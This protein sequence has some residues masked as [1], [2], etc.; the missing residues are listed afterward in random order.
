VDALIYTLL[1]HGH[2]QCANVQDY[3]LSPMTTSLLGQMHDNLP[4]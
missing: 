3:K 4:K 2:Y 1:H